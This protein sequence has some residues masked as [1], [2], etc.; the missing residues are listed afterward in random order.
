MSTKTMDMDDYKRFQ[1]SFPK[2]YLPLRKVVPD[3]A[4]KVFD[5]ICKTGHF[6]SNRGRGLRSIGFN[7]NLDPRGAPTG[8]LSV[9][10]ARQQPRTT[11]YHVAPP[12][13]EDLLLDI[14]QAHA[15]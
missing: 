6:D 11:S 2:K 8:E 14:A 1:N 13:H 3:I 5:E 12:S 7:W 4:G 15:E 9:R 10:F